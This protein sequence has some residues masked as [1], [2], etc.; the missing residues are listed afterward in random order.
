MNSKNLLRTCSFAS[1]WGIAMA[2]CAEAGAQTKVYR[3]IDLGAVADLVADIGVD[4]LG[5]YPVTEHTFGINDLAQVVGS[6][7]VSDD[8]H[9]FLW[10][11][12]N[13]YGLTA[14]I[15]Y[16]LHTLAD[17][18]SWPV[19]MGTVDYEV[20]VA[21]DINEDGWVVGAAGDSLVRGSPDKLHAWLWKVPT[22]VSGSP[23]N[24]DSYDLHDGSVD[25]SADSEFSIAMSLGNGGTARVVGRVFTNTSCGTTSAFRLDFNGSSSGGMSLMS[26]TGDSIHSFAAD[27]TPDGSSIVGRDTGNNGISC[28]PAPECEDD[29]SEGL[30]WTAGS[31]TTA[32]LD[33][34]R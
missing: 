1:M 31:F 12:R 29:P 11:P 19:G 2:L 3:L 6:A 14:H 7:V 17:L 18:N 25:N 10:L 4:G 15:R 16:D 28:N 20:S 30:F 21:N 22:Y 9:A 33:P 8:C 32:E 26:D 5:D 34:L 13:D 24:I 27:V 23:P